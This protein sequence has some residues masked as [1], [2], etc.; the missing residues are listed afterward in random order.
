ML[1]EV[2]AAIGDT[3]HARALYDELLPFADRCVVISGVL[4]Q[5]AAARLLGLL[6]TTL[7]RFDAA[8]RH[9]ATALEINRRIGARLWILHTRLNQ[10]S[11]WLSRGRRD[12]H[13]R[14]LATLDE[15]V[16]VS[17]PLG[18]AALAGRAQRRR[19]ERTGCEAG[20]AGLAPGAPSFS[21]TGDG[22]DL[23]RPGRR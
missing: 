2:A 23:R 12:D 10:A 4:G 13:E 17:E 22:G 7:K 5:G 21:A 16:E 6:A 18:L 20:T 19:G 11:M 8:E 15:L 1:A 14:A 3:R 9:L